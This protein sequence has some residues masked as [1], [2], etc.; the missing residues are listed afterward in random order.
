MIKLNHKSNTKENKNY[1]LHD[2]N[3]QFLDKK[4][5][6]PH[7]F[8]GGRFILCTFIGFQ[9]NRLEHKGFSVKRNADRNDRYVNINIEYLVLD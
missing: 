7:K 5:N 3:E 6:Q 9:L 2:A 1:E 4:A 8:I